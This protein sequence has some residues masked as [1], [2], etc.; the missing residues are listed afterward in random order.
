MSL[1]IDVRDGPV[2]VVEQVLDMAAKLQAAGLAEDF[3]GAGVGVP[4]PVQ[5]PVGIPVAP[6]IMPGWDCFLVREALSQKLGCTVMVDNDVNLVAA[7]ALSLAV[8]HA[9]QRA[10]PRPWAAPQDRIIQ[11]THLVVHHVLIIG[12][13]PS[14][15]AST[16]RADTYGPRSR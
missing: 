9:K 6:P 1:P 10:I 5:F 14:G 16:R 8:C 13:E 12:P 2:A 3:D 15:Y 7:P 4:G 11:P